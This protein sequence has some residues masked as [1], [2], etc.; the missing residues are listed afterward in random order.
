MNLQVNYPFIN[1]V[2]Q[3]ILNILRIPNVKHYLEYD[4]T[5]FGQKFF[6]SALKL[7]EYVENVDKLSPE[8][9]RRK[10]APFPQLKK[11]KGS[12][13]YPITLGWSFVSVNNLRNLN[14]LEAA[15]LSLSRRG[16]IMFLSFVL[17]TLYPN[18]LSFVPA[19]KNEVQLNQK[20]IEIFQTRRELF[21]SGV[22]KS[23]STT[24]TS[25][26]DTNIDE[27][28]NMDVDIGID[29]NDY[30]DNY[31]NKQGTSTE[32][33]MTHAPHSTEHTSESTQTDITQPYT[34]HTT[35]HTSE[36][37]QTNKPTDTTQSYTQKQQPHDTS[38]ITEHTSENKKANKQMDKQQLHTQQQTVNIGTPIRG[39]QGSI[40]SV[41]TPRRDLFQTYM[42]SGRSIRQ[43]STE[44]PLT[45]NDFILKKQNLNSNIPDTSGNR[46]TSEL[47]SIM[48]KQEKIQ[49]SL[50]A[51]YKQ[52]LFE[53]TSQ[54][55]FDLN[56][57]MKSSHYYV[58]NVPSDYLRIEY[59][60]V[61]D[62]YYDEFPSYYYEPF[63][64][65][66]EMQCVK[67]VNFKETRYVLNIN[68]DQ[69]CKIPY[70]IAPDSFFCKS[71]Q[72]LSCQFV[73]VSTPECVIVKSDIHPSPSYRFVDNVL[74]E[75]RNNISYAHA[76][77]LT[78]QERKSLVSD[79]FGYKNLFLGFIK[80]DEMVLY[81]F[82]FHVGILFMFSI[83]LLKVLR[84]K[85]MNRVRAYRQKKQEKVAR[86][87]FLH[88][89]HE[90]YK[91]RPCRRKKVNFD[92]NLQ[93]QWPEVV[94]LTL[95]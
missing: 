35:E 95:K 46:A 63:L 29:M 47:I 5:H 9:E 10:R 87:R 70:E 43:S 80:S 6:Q 68:N 73:K 50:M 56:T 54:L 48:S 67:L 13:N 11:S 41:I 21:S 2:L 86:E 12:D 74:I 14:D 25:N 49:F 84:N 45:K 57:L 52:F 53:I 77:H 42:N 58:K 1:K 7:K 83:K 32:T 19:E 55:I 40:E 94:P 4:G 18:D 44:N 30:V 34:Q 20:I 16:K 27:D 89:V 37:I 33:D 81:F 64:Y 71:W 59:E 82:I 39:R 65:C 3:G 36:S 90:E 72:N 24:D 78:E 62:I 51:I 85:I 61:V 31:N 23:K 92:E 93:T 79:V 76:L 17:G 26:T 38:R 69:Y 91:S 60:N 15:A 8:Q 28:N 22:R 66:Y 75:Q 88:N